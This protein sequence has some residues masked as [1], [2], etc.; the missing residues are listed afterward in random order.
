VGP[1]PWRGFHRVQLPGELHRPVALEHA[2][3]EQG[4]HDL[5][6]EEWRA[7]VLASRIDR[8][9]SEERELLQTLAVLRREF[10]L[11][12][13]RAIEI[14]RNQ[15]A[16]SLEL[17][18]TMSLARLLRDTARHVEARAMLTQ[19]MAGSPKASTPPT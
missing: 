7:V 2:I 12:F 10:P 17:R 6:H 8:L 5:F 3:F 18:A 13:E 16:K 4:L 11:C 1:A 14:A 19:S 9:R 15:R